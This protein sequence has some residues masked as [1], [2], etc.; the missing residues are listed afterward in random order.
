[1]EL[2]I[3]DRH[4]LVCCS[5]Q[6]I[7]RACAEVLAAECEEVTLCARGHDGLARTAAA[8]R[9]ADGAKV[10]TVAADLSTVDGARSLIRNLTRPPDILVL[11]T[12]RRP[13]ENSASSAKSW[14]D[15]IERGLHVPMALVTAFLPGMKGRGFGRI[16]HVT[17]SSVR[18]PTPQ[19]LLADTPRGALLAFLS[20]LAR[21]SCSRNVTINSVLVGYIDTP[22]LRD[23]WGSR[24][25][26]DGVSL[27]Q[28]THERTAKTPAG[29]LGSPLEVA[30]LCAFLSSAS[31]SFIAGQ[32]ILC[33]GGRTT[34]LV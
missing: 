22:G 14:D 10:N 25:A 3:A 21:E 20:G 19:F 28:Y 9:G 7:G 16:V 30:C 23:L 33:D 1:M 12:A 8:I 26:A 18:A 11:S 27:A 6:G 34:F 31:A 32:V 17:G 2:G 29:R 15:A 24:S 4:A 5:S 13:E